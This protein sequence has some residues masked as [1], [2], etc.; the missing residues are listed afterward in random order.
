MINA[1]FRSIKGVFLRNTIILN[2][3]R[4]K[5]NN[6]I[7]VFEEKKIRH[8]EHEDEMYFSVV[9]VIEALTDL[10]NPRNYR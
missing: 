2:Q 9:D 7:A 10:P 6:Q 1:I 8:I 5:M 3:N 4:T